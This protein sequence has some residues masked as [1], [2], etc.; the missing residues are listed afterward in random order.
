MPKLSDRQLLEIAYRG[1]YAVGL[2]EGTWFEP[3]PGV[4]TSEAEAFNEAYAAWKQAHPFD[5]DPRWK[6]ADDA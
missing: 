5:S 2:A 1:L 4:T 6:P 3:W